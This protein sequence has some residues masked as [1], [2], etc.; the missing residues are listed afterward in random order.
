MN[1]QKMQKEKTI[2]A[3]DMLL[4]TDMP[5]TAGSKM[6]VGYKSLITAEAITRAQMAGYTLVGK[7]DVGEFAIDLVGE[8]SANGALVCKSIFKNAAAE[9]RAA[10]QTGLVCLKPTYDAISRYGVVSVAPSS[11]AVSILA[12]NV[13]DCR[14]LFT[15]VAD[16][17]EEPSSICRIAVLTSLNDGIAEDV[18]QVVE[19][20]VTALQTSKIA[21]TYIKNDLISLA[22]AAWN[23]IL[24]AEL[25]KS[26]ARYDGI[27]YGH[28]AKSFSSLDE[29]YTNSR[30]EGFG[31]QVSA[32]IL[33]GSE[34]LS[35]QN[36]Q[37]VYDKAL[38]VR[39][40]IA[41]EFAKLFESFDAIL[42]PVCS[43]MEYT[44]QIM[45]DKYIAFE[46]NRFTAPASLVGLPVVVGGGVQLIGK[47]FSE[48]ALLDVAKLIAGE[49]R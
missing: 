21:V 14:A 9:M 5:T 37:K 3:D 47:A 16:K 48:Y 39:R 7:A 15:A 28:R 11:E 12:K 8:T 46:E 29:L 19:N 38:R 26:T 13:E 42:L 27:R 6:L 17:K 31:E 2:V 10:A 22:K 20:A 32:A 25:C 40:V 33:W 24:S 45:A 4:T 43:K 23:I 35:T 1:E 18:K 34:T 44:E 30:T 36:Y 49:G 41:E